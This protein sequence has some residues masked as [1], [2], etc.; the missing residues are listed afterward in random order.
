MCIPIPSLLLSCYAC[1]YHPYLC[2][3]L[4]DGAIHVIQCPQPPCSYSQHDTHPP[5]TPCPL[6]PQ[7]DEGWTPLHTASS[8]GDL[9]IVKALIQADKSNVSART[10]SGNTALHYAASKGHEDV[11]KFLI[12]SGA[13]VDAL[14]D[15][16]ATALHRAA[17]RGRLDV[18]KQLVASDANVNLQDSVGDTP[19]HHAALGGHVAILKFL[20]ENGADESI[21][22]ADGKKPVEV[23]QR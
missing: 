7:D 22:N 23:V 3:R 2:Y 17:A 13:D 21:T 9:R 11:V 8:L 14:D 6:Q 16:K 15:Y 18:V 1:L 12:E 4:R 20:F 10:S 19:L 5:P